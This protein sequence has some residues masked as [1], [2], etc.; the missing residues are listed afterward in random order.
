[1]KNREHTPS[2]EEAWNDIHEPPNASVEFCLGYYKIEATVHTGYGGHRTF[3]IENPCVT[4]LY[5]DKLID[6]MVSD[7]EVFRKTVHHQ[8]E[9]DKKRMEDCGDGE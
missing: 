8:V 2:P 3:T 7:I 9:A 4:G 1:M 5:P 6:R